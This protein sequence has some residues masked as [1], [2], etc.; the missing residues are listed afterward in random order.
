[1][2]TSAFLIYCIRYQLND[3]TLLVSQ[4]AVKWFVTYFFFFYFFCS[5]CFKGC[6]KKDWADL[7][8]FTCSG[9]QAPVSSCV[10]PSN[11]K[12]EIKTTG[13]FVFSPDFSWNCV[14]THFLFFCFFFQII[15]G[16]LKTTESTKRRKKKKERT[17]SNIFKCWV[18]IEWL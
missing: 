15:L 9:F 4:C 1:M 11:K 7:W 18:W 12:Q 17:F 3:I 14:I 2:R 6:D 13:Y 10:F 5:L 8:H 16:D